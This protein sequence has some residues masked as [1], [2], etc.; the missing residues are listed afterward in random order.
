ML[1]PTVGRDDGE[2]HLIDTVPTRSAEL[3]AGSAAGAV[4]RAAASMELSGPSVD[5]PRLLQG[6]AVYL[7]GAFNKAS[8]GPNRGDCVSLLFSLGAKVFDDPT[9][10]A[11]LIHQKSQVRTR[12]ELR[13]RVLGASMCNAPN[14]PGRFPHWQGSRVASKTDLFVIV[15]DN[16]PTC[17]LS[18][19]GD[20]Q[21]LNATL[22]NA[23][24]DMSPLVKVCGAG[25]LFDASAAYKKDLKF[26]EYPPVAEGS[27][28]LWD[29]TRSI[30]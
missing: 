16:S 29:I 27:K 13:W 8:G 14:T 20:T 21:T 4:L 23:I 9:K 6:V 12:D 15:C 10:A 11:T 19:T 25:W 26:D 22:N 30:V 17:P 7:L 24:H 28:L 1:P 3:E 2:I 5:P 18:T